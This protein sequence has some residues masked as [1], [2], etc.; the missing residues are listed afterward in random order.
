[1]AIIHV[2]EATVG[3]PNSGRMSG[4]DGDLVTMLDYALPLNGWAI[5]YTSGNV[6]VYRPG[7]GNRF[8]LYVNDAAAV[9]GDARLSVVRGCENASAAA[10]A[11]IIDPFPTVAKL[12]DG[13]SNWLKSTTANTTARNFDLYVGTTWVMFFCNVT[14]ATNVWDL[15][16]FGDWSPTL[17]GDPY[18]TAC[19]VRN[20]TSATTVSG[21]T[22]SWGASASNVGLTSYNFARSYDGTVK[23]TTGGIWS[24]LVGVIGTG[25]STQAQGGPTTGI[26]RCKMVSLDTGSITTASSTSISLQQRAYVPNLWLPL[27][28][29]RGA[30]NSRDTFTDT[31]YNASATFRIFCNSNVATAGFIVVEE[32]DTWSPPSG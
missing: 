26:D 4:T 6:R 31:A 16:L 5:E 1:M 11:S 24:P 10:P 2:T 19:V 7:S 15:G 18:C 20:S 12:A 14:G 29:G 8:R 3:A 23:S 27:H 25:G 32:T 9:S 30:V 17:S 28:A 21:A 13:S 22:G